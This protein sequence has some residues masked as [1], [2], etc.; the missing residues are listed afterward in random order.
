M[1]EIQSKLNIVTFIDML[2]FIY[3]VR[4]AVIYII[5]GVFFVLFLFFFQVFRL[6]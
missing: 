2:I 5:V 1:M 4:E 6:I 3:F